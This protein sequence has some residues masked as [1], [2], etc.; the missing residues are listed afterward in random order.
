MKDISWPTVLVTLVILIALQ[1]FAPQLMGSIAS[2]GR[3]RG[4]G[5]RGEG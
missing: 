3:G 4:G 1:R 5:R 2:V